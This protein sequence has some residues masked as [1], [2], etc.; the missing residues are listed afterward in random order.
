MTEEC[1]GTEGGG[2]MGWAGEPYGHGLKALMC[3]ALQGSEGN[4]ILES[5]GSPSS[6]RRKGQGQNSSCFQHGIKRFVVFRL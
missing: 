2:L 1:V 6:P 3:S 4:W 5:P